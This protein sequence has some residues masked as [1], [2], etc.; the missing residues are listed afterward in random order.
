MGQRGG[1]Q[2]RVGDSAGGP[3][4]VELSSQTC[5]TSKNNLP[6]IGKKRSQ[7]NE[8]NCKEAPLQTLPCFGH[9]EGRMIEGK[10]GARET[11]PGRMEN[12]GCVV[13]CG[14]TMWCTVC[15]VLTVIVAC[16]GA[17]W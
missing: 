6:P 5:K 10:Q 12:V 3:G 14:D 9:V 11:T 7:E 17:T 1:R 16:C 13:V 4:R 8:N 2:G 15:N